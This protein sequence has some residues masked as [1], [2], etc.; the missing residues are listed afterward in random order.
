[1]SLY[2]NTTNCL[3][4][5]RANVILINY[6]LTFFSIIN[7]HVFHHMKYCYE[8]YHQNFRVIL[9]M[10]LY[11]SMFSTK[12]FTPALRYTSGC[13]CIYCILITIC[14]RGYNLSITHKLTVWVDKFHQFDPFQELCQNGKLS[15][16]QV[17]T[18]SNVHVKWL[19]TF[20]IWVNSVTIVTV[21]AHHL[22]LHYQGYVMIYVT[23]IQKFFRIEMNLT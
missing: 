14:S 12:V 5:K 22:I 13:V 4:L 2:R 3:H 19:E 6:N 9:Y 21:Y 15:H 23:L 18:L 7:I 1:M 20:Q 17:F 16:N 10:V 11:T 8:Y